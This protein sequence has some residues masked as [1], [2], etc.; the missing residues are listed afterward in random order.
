VFVQLSY[1]AGIF[2]VHKEF[3]AA[4]AKHD[5]HFHICSRAIHMLS[6]VINNS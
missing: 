1:L 3:T 2:Y 6:S 4:T 5:A